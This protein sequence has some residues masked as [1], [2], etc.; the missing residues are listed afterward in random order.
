MN[1]NQNTIPPSRFKPF[2]WDIDFEKLD[3]AKHQKYV[4]A[5]LLD[6][7]DFDAWKWVQTSFP[8][9]LIINTVKTMRDFSLKSAS[10][11]ATIYDI[12]LNELIC[13]QQPYL[14]TRRQLWPY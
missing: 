1:S 9:E 14:Q 2:F 5:R 8:K 11:W 13:F 6:K 7:G 4:I 3:P 12:P 10:F